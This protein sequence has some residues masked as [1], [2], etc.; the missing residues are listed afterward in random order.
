MPLRLAISERI[1]TSAVV[2]NAGLHKPEALS[3]E[4]LRQ[5][6]EEYKAAILDTLVPK[7]T[8]VRKVHDDELNEVAIKACILE[9]QQEICVRNGFCKDCQDLFDDW[10]D[11]GGY[12]ASIHRP[13]LYRNRCGLE[14]YCCTILSHASP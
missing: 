10:P 4:E 9:L 3:V 1:V 12:H 6:Y 2:I 11:L 7:S 13:I 14:A 5:W 8:I